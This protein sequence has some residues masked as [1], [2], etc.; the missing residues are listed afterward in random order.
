[1]NYLRLLLAKPTKLPAKKRI[2]KKDLKIQILSFM[3][4]PYNEHKNIFRFLKKEAAAE[5][6][7]YKIIIK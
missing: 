7:T 2:L 1:M 6:D 4:C 5:D 3:R